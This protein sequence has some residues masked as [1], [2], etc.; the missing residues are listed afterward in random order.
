M[1][2]LRKITCCDCIAHRPCCDFPFRL[3]RQTLASPARIG[4][5]F[6]VAHMRDRRVDIEGT[7]ALQGHF[8]PLAFALL[9]V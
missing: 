3:G 7:Q 9:P 8:V 6:I 5:G 2:R 1:L 4:G